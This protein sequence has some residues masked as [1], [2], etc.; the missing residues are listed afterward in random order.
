MTPSTARP[1]RTPKKWDPNGDVTALGVPRCTAQ[2]KRTGRRCAAPAMKGQRVCAK[3]G[4]RSPQAL[5]KAEQRLAEV[6]AKRQAERFAIRRD[7]SPSEALLEELQWTAGNV[8]YFRLK[9]RELGEERL[10]SGVSKIV[11]DGGTAAK[12][13]RP[14]KPGK[15]QTTVET[16]PSIWYELWMREREHLV[17]VSSAAARAGVEQRR[18]EL[19]EN[20]GLL[21]ATVVRRILDSLLA[22][23][24]AQGHDVMEVWDQEIRVI[25]PREFRAIEAVTTGG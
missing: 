1:K 22:V 13:G 4:G 7:V 23:L 9:V 19:A 18:I 15:R 17:K 12:D 24:I 16:K 25:V 11:E 10:V 20:T 3:H 6:E 21:V 8:E 14:A 5:A 2:A